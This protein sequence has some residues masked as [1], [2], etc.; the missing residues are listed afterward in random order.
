MAQ[1]VRSRSMGRAKK[2][3]ASSTRV[4]GPLSLIAEK[5]VIVAAVVGAIALL[6]LLYGLIAGHITSFPRPSGREREVLSQ[7]A[8]AALTGWVGTVTKIL[9]WAALLGTVLAMA[10]YYDAPSTIGFSAALGGFLYLGLPAI[11]GIILQQQYRTA[12]ELTD[13]IIAG[14]QAS[15]KLILII[16]AARGA[17][18][19]FLAATR[20]AKRFPVARGGPV[21][22]A[23]TKPRTLLRQCWELAHCRS[24]G[25]ICP[26]LRER[27]SCWKRGSGCLCDISL[28]ERLATGAEAWA[29]EEVTAI[30]YRAGQVRRPCH[31]CP[32]YEEHQ[33]YKFRVAQWL[34]YP[35]TAAVIFAG[36][37]VLHI[38]YK[39]LLDFTDR[40]VAALKFMPTHGY[41]PANPGGVQSVVLSSN[42]EWVFLACLG[43]LLVS[44]FLK[45][46][47]RA[48][49]KWGW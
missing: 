9:A 40:V 21:G 38:A 1:R 45:G 6:Y 15:G 24:G 36:L 29:H 20:R 2:G 16:A 33:N 23:S 13:I 11:I 17:V 26:S 37:P 28:A 27:R 47:E 4:I 41:V 35:A 43:L 18:H 5:L 44:Y 25:T 10:R 32:I 49:F 8:Q 3:G 48:I 31:K 14:A 46:I 19:M 42:V 39:Q 34:A 22:A 12:N 30:R 7:T